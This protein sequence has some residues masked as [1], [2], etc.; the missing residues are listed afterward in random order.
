MHC[1]YEIATSKGWVTLHEEIK[2]AA[3]QDREYQQKKQ[4]VQDV[5]SPLRQ[6]GYDLKTTGILYYKER[7]YIPNHAEIKKKILDENHNSPYAGHPGYQ[8]LLL[9]FEKNATRQE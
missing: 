8:N 7:I 9:S 3:E 2:Q 1:L 6:Q 4:Q 5:T